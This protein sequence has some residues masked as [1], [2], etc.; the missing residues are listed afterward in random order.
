MM[1]VSFYLGNILRGEKEVAELCKSRVNYSP[2]SP[3]LRG[4]KILSEEFGLLKR[5]EIFLTNLRIR[6]CFFNTYGVI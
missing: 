1:I 4:I 2:Y 6:F 3:L 5:L